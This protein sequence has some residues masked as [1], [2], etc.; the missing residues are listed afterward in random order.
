MTL[1]PETVLPSR[2]AVIDTVGVVV[3]LGVELPPPPHPPHIHPKNHDCQ[4]TGTVTD[5]IVVVGGFDT[6]GCVDVLGLA[7]SE[8]LSLTVL[9]AFII[10]PILSRVSGPKNPTDGFIS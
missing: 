8:G 3:S 9:S 6:S 4:L 10:S 2:G 1:A 5:G 7:H